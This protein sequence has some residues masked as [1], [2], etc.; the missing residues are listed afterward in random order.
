MTENNCGCNNHKGEECCGH[1]HEHE[2]VIYLTLEDDTELKCD[3]IGTFEV[4]NKDYIA[5]LP[6]GEDQV[7][8][9]E[10]KE[11]ENGLEIL[12]IEDD[13]EFDKVSEAFMDAFSEAIESIDEE[14][15]D[16]EE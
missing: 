12:N 8:L 14:G 6:E 11:D 9:Y 13:E 1:D 5:L 16:E 15:F 3:I 7:L 10:Y 4:D 2:E